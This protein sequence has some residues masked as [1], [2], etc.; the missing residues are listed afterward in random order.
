[1]QTQ[2]SSQS[3]DEHPR[4]AARSPRP[5]RKAVLIIS[6]VVIAG[7]LALCGLVAVLLFG[8]RQFYIPSAGMEPTLMGHTAGGDDH[9]GGTYSDTVNDYILVST[10]AYRFHE[11]RRGDI[12]VFL[13]PARADM[14]NHP[15]EE[16]ILAKRIIGLPGDT[17]ELK[18]GK[19]ARG[20]HTATA[21]VAYRNGQPLDE[22]W[23]GK[24]PGYIKEPMD[25]PQSYAAVY[26]VDK[27][28]K[29]GPNELFVMGNNR[30]DSNDSRYW[31]PLERSRI[32]G[33][34]VSILSP[35]DRQRSFP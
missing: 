11:P 6:L 23:D 14:Q 8:P 15:P 4:V 22:Y 21:Y 31:G 13:A 1:M 25:D 17:I 35:R 34:V 30:N 2:P 9:A 26:A 7:F 28:L 24:P 5:A 3:P 16:N 33:K 19:V 18:R 29:L 27:P 12:V 20:G 32:I 10:G